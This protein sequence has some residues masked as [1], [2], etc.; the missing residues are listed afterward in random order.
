MKFFSSLILVNQN[1]LQ[2]K[3][4]IFLY[5]YNSKRNYQCYF[6]VQKSAPVYYL[7]QSANNYPKSTMKIWNIKGNEFI[8]IMRIWTNY[9]FRGT[10]VH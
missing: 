6:A 2:M 9:D 1:D 8:L 7:T 5:S 10:E 3:I 4:I